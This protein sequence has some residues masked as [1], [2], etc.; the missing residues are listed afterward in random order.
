MDA[1]IKYY[2]FIENDGKVRDYY[3]YEE[4]VHVVIVEKIKTEYWLV[5]GYCVDDVLKHRKRYQNYRFG[6]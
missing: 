2:Q 4:M 3:W 5:T 6:K 1:R